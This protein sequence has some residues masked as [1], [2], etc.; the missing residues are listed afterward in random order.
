MKTSNPLPYLALFASMLL[1]SCSTPDTI[2]NFA[3]EAD[4]E[5][6]FLKDGNNPNS[7]AEKMFNL[8]YA[9]DEGT[10]QT[11]SDRSFDIGNRDFSGN[12][13][14]FSRQLSD[15][16]KSFDTKKFTGAGSNEAE[17]RFG[18]KE[19]ATSDSL[20]GNKQSRFANRTARGTEGTYREASDTV[21]TNAYRESSKLLRAGEYRR[22]SAAQDKNYRASNFPQRPTTAGDAPVNY[23]TEELSVDDVKGLLNKGSGKKDLGS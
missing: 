10:G 13:D 12:N 2:N 17:K 7:V 9:E 6:D 4:S 1:A 16:N 23:R 18:S 11:I 3:D 5:N 15:R 20:I 22:G 19:F 21:P 8:N 14:T